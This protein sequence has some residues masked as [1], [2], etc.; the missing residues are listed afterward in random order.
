MKGIQMTERVL[1]RDFPTRPEFLIPLSKD[2]LQELGTFAT[3]WSQVDWL[4]IMLVTF[5]TKTDFAHVELM[6]ENMTTGPRVN[7]LK[8][9]C[10]NSPDETDKAIVKLLSDN[11]GL[12]EDR[13]HIIHGLWGIEWGEP[14]WNPKAACF[15]QKKQTQADRRDQTW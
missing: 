7:L 14:D 10:A 13:N 15:Y 8:K 4:M 5:I 11:S 6:M 9:L 1:P 3:L 12:I 2:E